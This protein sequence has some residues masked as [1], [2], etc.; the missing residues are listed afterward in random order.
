MNRLRL[1]I[2]LNVSLE[3]A[4]IK[5]LN[6]QSENT[7]PDLDLDVETPSDSSHGDYSSSIALKLSKKMR[8]APHEIAQTLIQ[9]IEKPD[10]VEKIK[11]AGP[12]FINFQ[13]SQKFLEQTLNSITGLKTKFGRLGVGHNTRALVEYSS[14]NIA[15]PLGVHH[16]LSTII[17]QTLANMFKFAGYETVTLNWPGD[18][19]TQFG[20]LIYAYKR[21]GKRGRSKKRP[22]K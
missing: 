11:I 13:L 8:K 7:A 18:W 3:Q 1:K 17:G 22:L 16:L 19:G 2:R 12:G 4:L 6:E 20:K 9:K 15:K 5:L 21:W 14:P 10:Y